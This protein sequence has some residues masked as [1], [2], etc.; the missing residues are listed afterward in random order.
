[1]EHYM[2]FFRILTI[3]LLSIIGLYVIISLFLPDKVHVERSIEIK[4]N[5][6]VPFELVNILKHWEAWDPWMKLDS[7]QV[8]TYE[9]TGKG[10]SSSYKWTSKSKDVGNGSVTITESVPN[11]L[12]KTE[13]VFEGQGKAISSFK[14][15]E[16]EGITKV[17]WSFDSDLDFMSRMFGLMFDTWLGK[18]FEEGLAKIKKISESTPPST[19]KIEVVD[20]PAKK[21]LFIRDSCSMSEVAAYLGKAYGEL[22]TFITK[23]KI[24]CTEPPIAITNSW[25]KDSWVFEAAFIISEANIKTDG[26]IQSGDLYSGK[27]VKGTYFGPYE[28]VEPAYNEIMKFIENHGL[29]ISGRSWE[30]YMNDPQNTPPDKLQTD[31]YFPVM[32]K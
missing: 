16:K 5:A 13:L 28:K 8:R 15:E 18:D 21:I 9:G 10:K 2:K 23:N 19:I 6:A 32:K 1:M 3:V 20:V 30:A 17:I 11:T 29:K 27:A 12:I 7:N 24:S 25:D 31:I 14:F 4:T 26:R 22:M